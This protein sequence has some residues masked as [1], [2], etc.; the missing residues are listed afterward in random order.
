MSYPRRTPTERAA[1]SKAFGDALN[2][3]CA[4]ANAYDAAIAALRDLVEQDERNR[5]DKTHGYRNG[6]PVWKWWQEGRRV[7]K[8]A[9][10]LEPSK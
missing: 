6:S 4:K 9:D 3:V 1:D 2:R 8:A 7:I 5:N 10:K